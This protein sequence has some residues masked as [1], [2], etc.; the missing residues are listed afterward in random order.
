MKKNLVLS[1]LLLLT[2]L[3][4]ALT[5]LPF[6][7]SQKIAS[8]AGE[9]NL[10]IP[11]NSSISGDKWKTEAFEF[12]IISRFEIKVNYKET[13]N[14]ASPS[15]LTSKFIHSSGLEFS[16]FA[17][18]TLKFTPLFGL[19]TT[20]VNQDVDESTIEVPNF[21]DVSDAEGKWELFINRQPGT[22]DRIFKDSE[23]TIGI[24]E[25]E[26]DG[27]ASCS[28]TNSNFHLINED[29]DGKGVK[30]RCDDDSRNETGADVLSNIKNKPN[31]NIVFKASE[32]GKKLQNILL[33]DKQYNFTYCEGEQKYRNDNC[34]GDRFI[35]VSQ[36]TITALNDG[37]SVLS[38]KKTGADSFDVMV[39]G[40]GNVAATSTGGGT[41]GAGAVDDNSCEA[42]GGAMAWIMCSAIQLLDE[43]FSFI[44]NQIQSLLE[45][46][47]GDLTGAN[48]ESINVPV[49]AKQIRNFAYI[50]LIPVML[51]MVLGTA[52]GFE[53]LSAYTVKKA[54]PRMVAATIFIAL[55]S[56]ITLFL[57]SFTNTLGA[58]IGGLILGPLGVGNGGLA[59]ILNPASAAGATGATIL[60]AV[61]ATLV[62]GPAIIGILFS[63]LLVGFVAILIG[64]AILSIRQVMVIVLSLLAPLA[65]LAWIFPGNDKLWKLW[66]GTFTKLLLMYPLIV[67]L[68]ASGKV[69]SKIMYTTQGGA[70]GGPMTIFLAITAYIAPYFFIPKT[71]QWAGGMFATIAGAASNR[72]AGFFAKQKEKRGEKAARG[73]ELQGRKWLAKR[74]DVT[75]GL[76][77]RGDTA[78]TRFGRFAARTAQRTVG[79]RDIEALMSARQAAVQK[80]ANDKIATGRDDSVRGST[81]NLARIN[82][83]GGFDAVLAAQE[84]AGIKATDAAA[85]VRVG[86]NGERQY[87]TL[88]GGW[89]GE[90]AVHE[91]KKLY[92]KDR[93]SQQAALSYE[94]RKAMDS[95][96]VAG[97]SEGYAALATEDWGMSDTEAGGAWIGSAFENQAQHIE[98]K[99]TDWETGELKGGGADMVKEIY[100]KK[101]NYPLAQM[102]AHTIEQLSSTYDR[103]RGID[104]EGN[105]IPG[106]VPSEKDLEVQQKIKEIADTFEFRSQQGEVDG[107]PIPPR[108]GQAGQQPQVSAPGAA[109]VNTA[110][111]TLYKKTRGQSG[112]SGLVDQN[113]RP[114]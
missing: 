104:K 10:C 105:A 27:I 100:E 38:V 109:S 26:L 49:A 85:R 51:V 59:E 24:E 94:M 28:G 45:V 17:S 86:T 4:S 36:G 21:G 78:K 77:T 52:L 92:G 34:N 46:S 43:G 60:A 111:Q 50:I 29:G 101:G 2:I 12:E 67:L 107:Q 95:D 30:W 72:G 70:G 16:T 7:G 79:G 3:C 1:G 41:A 114:L 58:G 37:T 74:A 8:A 56:Q 98:Y 84:A 25:D 112:R 90:S 15:S 87:K 71:F 91:G 97:I 93:F 55:S 35:D 5:G 23:Y 64:F 53:L 110:V 14:C 44:D 80:E 57:V 18:Q 54:F 73:K 68:I 88:G 102:S 42:K 69:F 40:A 108:P 82:K 106:F 31:F 96:Q 20:T 11:S 9:D 65:I 81:V 33:D 63:Y 99:N 89:V 48:P 61:G 22:I 75:R 39:A 113:G 76:G 103:A 6:A 13:G 83:D 66:W 19:Y 32:D 47:E 62:L